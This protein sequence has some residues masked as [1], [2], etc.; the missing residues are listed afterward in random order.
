VNSD[1]KPDKEGKPTMSQSFFKAC[2]LVLF[3]IIALAIAFELLARFWGWLALIS[4]MVVGIWI[5][6]KIYRAKRDR[7]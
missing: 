1:K 4:A 2:L 7:W 5:A 6:V 3:G